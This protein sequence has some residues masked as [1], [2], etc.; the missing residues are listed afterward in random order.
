MERKHMFAIVIVVIV[1]VGVGSIPVLIGP[2]TTIPLQEIYIYETIWRGPRYFDPH[3]AYDSAS[4]E[5][6]DQCYETLYTYPWGS[7]ERGNHPE[8][9]PTV[10]LLAAGPPTITENGTVYTITL[11]QGVTFA[12]GTPF[13]ASAAVWNFK[14]AMKMF[15]TAGPVWMIAEPIKGGLAVK[16]AA[17]TYGPTSDEFKAAFDA[18]DA[19]DAVEATGTYE[20]T[21]RLAQS[22]AY[23]IPAMTYTVGCMISPTFAEEHTW[24]PGTK[25]GVDYGEEFT[26]MYNHTCGTGPYQ[27][28][29]WKTDEYVHMVLNEDYWRA[30]RTEAAIAPPA[31]AGSI[32][33]IW[34]RTNED[35]T[36]MNLNLKTGIADDTYWPTT[37]ADEIYDNITL[38]SKD[39]NIFFR[40]GG[41]AFV[42]M[43]FQFQMGLMNWTIGTNTFETISP[44][45]W[46]G[47][48]KAFAYIFDFDAFIND[49]TSGWSYKA[50]GPIPGGML[51]HNASYWTEHYAPEIAV[52]YW[53]EAMQDSDFVDVMNMIEG[54]ILYYYNTQGTLH[55]QFA[56]LLKEGFDAMKL[57][58]GMNTTGIDYDVNFTP[59]GLEWAQFL[60]LGSDAENMLPMWLV[61]W[62][63]D[64]ADSDNFV[65]PFL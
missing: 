38:G 58:P 32:K 7:G 22:A 6:I 49:V 62:G 65:T 52:D 29:E 57:L 19:T 46:R 34:R 30:G 16:D 4:G 11:R 55:G 31:Y 37:H 25:Y 44:F 60:Y 59:I 64:Y 14:R 36:N 12:D 56:T 10:P 48:R 28:V 9:N 42:V 18:W 40:T 24:T 50:Q 27:V 17:F 51:Y 1:I 3:I 35:Q 41:T 39:P 33:E 63:A 61:G 45:A 20:I 53:N 47:L 13:N 21:Y 15:R 2:P 54:E 26:Y 5:I 43:A 8:V 23:F